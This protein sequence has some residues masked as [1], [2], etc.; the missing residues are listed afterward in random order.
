MKEI[1]ICGTIIASKEAAERLVNRIY[2]RFDG[3]MEASVAIGDNEDKLVK[4]GLITWAE[5]EAAELA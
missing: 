2:R 4:S 3:S 5:V 1:L